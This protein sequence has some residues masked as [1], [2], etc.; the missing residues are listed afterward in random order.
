MRTSLASTSVSAPADQSLLVKDAYEVNDDSSYN[1]IVD[2]L[3]NA[4]S[5]ITKALRTT[6]GMSNRITQLVVD[7]KTGR[8]NN[9]NILT[10]VSGLLGGR[11]ALNGLVGD[12]GTGIGKVFGMDPRLTNQVMTVVTDSLGNTSRSYNGRGGYND[13]SAVGVT[14]AI[15]AWLGNKEIIEQ[16]DLGTEAAFIG[17]LLNQ[18]VRAGIPSA[19]DTL[20]RNADNDPMRRYIVVRNIAP[21]LFSGDLATM[22]NTLKHVSPSVIASARPRFALEFLSSFRLPYSTTKNEYLSYKNRIIVL[23]GRIDP[24]WSVSL[25]GDEPLYVLEP[26]TRMSKDAKAVFAMS[27]DYLLQSTIAEKFASKSVA[28]LLKG[29]YRYFP[30]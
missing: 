1:K 30:V 24:N 2:V 27:S 10:R 14:R 8:L 28:T 6:P 16:F 7:A 12:V 3:K 5:D 29:Q 20:L 17:E 9:Q 19:I 4:G 22:E 26:F 18:A 25:R 15:Q 23:L 21:I 13:N 11:R